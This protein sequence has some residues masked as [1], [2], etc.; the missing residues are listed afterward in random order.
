ML[1]GHEGL[2]VI[3][4]YSDGS[5]SQPEQKVF[6]T[7]SFRSAEVPAEKDFCLSGEANLSNCRRAL[8]VGDGTVGQ[9]M[10]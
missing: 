8:P 5:R 2:P 10:M 1:D 3:P 7:A 6:N 9:A 4:A